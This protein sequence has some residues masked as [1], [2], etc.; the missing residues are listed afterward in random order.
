MGEDDPRN[1]FLKRIFGDFQSIT[2]H[3]LMTGG[4]TTQISITRT[5]RAG[6]VTDEGTY[7]GWYKSRHALLHGG[8][9]TFMGYDPA[10]N[11]VGVIFIGK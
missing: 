5:G 2:F 8:T 1:V 3:T 11:T 4:R 9:V 7:G 6:A 10:S